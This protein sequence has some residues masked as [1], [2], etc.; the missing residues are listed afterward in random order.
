MT[1]ASSPMSR[2]HTRYLEP[3]P[4]QNRVTPFGNLITDSARGAWMGNRGVLHDIN[5]KL[6]GRRW[7]T[8]NWIICSLSFKK[9]HRK[10]MSPGR[11][12]ELFFLD[13]ATA[14]AAG[15]RPCFE[16]RRADAVA[17]RRAWTDAFGVRRPTADA[18]DRMIHPE[19]KQP[20]CQRP[21]ISDAASLPDGAFLFQ[22]HAPD[23]ALLVLHRHL[24]RWTPTGYEAPVAASGQAGTLVTPPTSVAV[25]LAG[26]SV[27]IHSS[28]HG[29]TGLVI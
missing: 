11:Y 6:T 8:L 7:T 23:T 4:L 3:M 1:H 28:A 19:R 15:H 24:W 2:Q 5:R 12:S 29:E 16:C 17:F 13:E 10:V 21:R 9:R 14:L 18:M 20:P 27:Q 25:L 26:Y 22:D